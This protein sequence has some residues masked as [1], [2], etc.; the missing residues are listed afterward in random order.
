MTTEPFCLSTEN[1]EGK[2]R[3]LWGWCH[4]RMHPTCTCSQRVTITVLSFRLY[5]KKQNELSRPR[6]HDPFLFWILQSWGPNRVVHPKHMLYPKATAWAICL[7]SLD[8]YLTLY[9]LPKEKWFAASIK[10][11][12][13]AMSSTRLVKEGPWNSSTPSLFK[14]AGTTWSSSNLV[15]SPWQWTHLSWPSHQAPPATVE[16]LCYFS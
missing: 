12:E 9:V 3:S 7:S 2:V 8:L 5:G 4:C 11:S 6:I 14:R 15:P 1:P 10:S 13:K 16:W